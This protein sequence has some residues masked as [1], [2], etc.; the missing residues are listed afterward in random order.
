MKII[1]YFK[2]LILEFRVYLSY[3][4]FLVRLNSWVADLLYAM[5][6]DEALR[7]VTKTRFKLASY[8]E[9]K[10]TEAYYEAL[11]EIEKLI[12]EKNNI[13]EAQEE[14]QQHAHA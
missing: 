5:P 12:K 3:E 4:L 2:N 13:E 6:R 11:N 8:P 14:E 7:Q 1:Q 9:N 10:F